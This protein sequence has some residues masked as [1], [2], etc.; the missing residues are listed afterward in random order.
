MLQSAA[1]I[2]TTDY[3][4]GVDS[5]SAPGTADFIRMR[6]PGADVFEFEWCDDFAYAR[7][8]A[9]KRVPADCDWWYWMDADDVIEA[10]EGRESAAAYLDALR[11]EVGIV[12]ARYVEY[13]GLGVV[14]DIPRERFIRRGVTCHWVDRL[15]EFLR[16]SAP[17]IIEHTDA[18]VWRQ[19]EP[20]L[21][22][23]E[24]NLRLLRLCIDQE[25][26]RPRWW[27]FLAREELLRGNYRRAFDAL[28]RHIDL[29]LPSGDS[30]AL[31][32]AWYEFARV[33]RVVV[34]PSGALTFAEI[35]VAGRPLWPES[36]LA[37]AEARLN[38]GDLVG[39]RAAIAT[40]LELAPDGPGRP[41]NKGDQETKCWPYLVVCEI[42]WREGNRAAALRAIET[43]VAYR[44]EP[45]LVEI[46]NSLSADFNLREDEAA[47]TNPTND[48]RRTPERLPSQSSFGITRWPRLTPNPTKSDACRSDHVAGA[49][50]PGLVG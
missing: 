2:G 23:S 24:R 20:G 10:Q 46:R 14:N 27:R 17:V 48:T 15:H 35:Q 28:G 50:L 9:L 16:P 40:C 43:A 4:I 3:A 41:N 1:L 36:H 13:D 6:A 34:S 37:L 22:K 45:S 39:A 47:E 12:V 31:Y 8:L 26:T 19:E 7:N 42:E 33:A 11:S 5:K 30:D 29:M 32:E 21:L 18:F 44:P 25:P 49:Q 38:C